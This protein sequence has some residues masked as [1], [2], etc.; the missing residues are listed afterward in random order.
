MS[1]AKKKQQSKSSKK[2]KADAQT[3]PLN[4]EGGYFKEEWKVD[5]GKFS[6]DTLDVE[7][8]EDN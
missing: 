8:D 5:V 1:A 6:L 2:E 3:S 7:D 4:E